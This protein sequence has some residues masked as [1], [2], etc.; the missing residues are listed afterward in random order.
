MKPILDAITDVQ[1][2]LPGENVLKTLTEVLD[3]AFQEK[4]IRKQ[5]VHSSFC[6]HMRLFDHDVGNWTRKLV[7]YVCVCDDR[8][9][10]KIWQHFFKERKDIGIGGSKTR[11]IGLHGRIP[12]HACSNKGQIPEII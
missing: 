2:D 5:S 7:N 3:V 1:Y 11:G 8:L 6:N 12:A 10:K 4:R 9:V